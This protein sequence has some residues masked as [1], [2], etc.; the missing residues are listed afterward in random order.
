MRKKHLQVISMAMIM[1]LMI[2]GMSGCGKNADAMVEQKVTDSMAEQKVTDAISEG[3]KQN[4][5]K[6]GKDETV[7]VFLDNSGSVSK[8]TVNDVIKNQKSGS[9]ADVSELSDI[10]NIK[11]EE[12]YEANGNKLTWQAGGEDITY[13]GNSNKELPIDMKITYKLDGNEVTA[14]QLAGATGHVEMTYTF[15][16]NTELTKKVDGV[17]RTL[18]VPFLAASGMMLPS[19][20]C[21]NIT[22]DNGK[23]LEEGGSSVVVGYAVP[24]VMD[25]IENQVNDKNDIFEKINIPDSFTVEADVVDFKQD[26]CLTVV[27]PASIDKEDSE[28]INLDDITGELDELSDASKQLVDGS[29]SLDDGAGEL[30]DGAG[31]IADATKELMSGT[32]TLKDGTGAAKDGAGKLASGAGELYQG[33]NDANAGTKKLNAGAKDAV[34]GSKKIKGGLET[35]SKGAADAENGAKQVA[36][37]SNTIKKSCEQLKTGAKSAKD[38]MTT[39]SNGITNVDTAM[40]K[41]NTALTSEEGLKNG[42]ASLAAGAAAAEAGV[43][44]LVAALQSTPDSVTAK[45]SEIME[46]VTALSGIK[47]SEELSATIKAIDTAIASNEASVPLASVLSAATGGKITSYETYNKLVQANY[48]IIALE[49]VKDTMTAAVAGNAEQVK[50]LQ[51]GMSSLKDGSAALSAGIN[52]LADSTAKIEEGTKSLVTGAQTISTGMGTLYDGAD[53]LAAGAVTLNTGANSL[54]SGNKQLNSGASTLYDGMKTL[55]SGIGT[56]SGGIS[57]LYKGTGKLSTGAAALN[58]GIGDLENGIIKLDTGAIRLKKGSAKLNNGAGDLYEGVVTLKGGTK[59]L[60]DGMLQF[61]EEG[62]EKITDLFGDDLNDGIS[63]IKAIFDEGKA[64]K[65]YS[66]ISDEMDGTVKFI[67]KTE[68]IGKEEE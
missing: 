63:L 18:V 1:S 59:E 56:L 20:R 51:T 52:T 57:S 31:K 44:Q 19:D 34:A 67:Y 38:G 36:D 45:I 29:S 12:T 6:T 43:N 30:L 22:V 39:L 27:I 13:Q 9:L 35:L 14:D 11:G 42:A 25:M 61:D 21:T 23:V 55:D 8:I 66:G 62:I 33:I 53:K 28:D 15:T 10:D 65:N 40:N 68:G 24:G 3:L 46:S 32:V 37:G 48:S 7:Y 60:S 4:T 50:Q 2:S 26:M 16:N 17:D 54:Y 58:K 5:V 47:T 64:Y 41:V 49:G